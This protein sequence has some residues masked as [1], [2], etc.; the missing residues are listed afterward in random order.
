MDRRQ[1]KCVGGKN[2]CGILSA[3]HNTINNSFCWF[4]SLF[5]DQQNAS[6]IAA[7]A[8]ITAATATVTAAASAAAIVVLILS[9]LKVVLQE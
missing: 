9:L 7:V 3:V 4:I 5:V 1:G 8:D 6:S 2:E